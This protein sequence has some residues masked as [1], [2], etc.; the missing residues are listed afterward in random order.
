MTQPLTQTQGQQKTRPTAPSQK[1]MVCREG[2]LFAGRYILGRMLTKTNYST[3]YAAIFFPR[4]LNAVTNPGARLPKKPQEVIIKTTPA[5]GKFQ[6]RLFIE[7]EV[8]RARLHP[9]HPRYLDHG[10][11]LN[12]STGE[13]VAFLGM[14]RLQGKTVFEV[15][16]ERELNLSEAIYTIMVLCD[17]LEPLHQRNLLYR[18][19]S[20]NNIILSLF[21][22]K[23]IDF[24]SIFDLNS[25]RDAATQEKLL[26]GSEDYLAPEHTVIEVKTIQADIYSLGII[27]YELITN[28]NPMSASIPA[29]TFINHLNKAMPALSPETIT[30][31]FH[32]LEALRHR[33]QIDRLTETLDNITQ[34]ATAKKA[35]GRQTNLMMLREE[36]AAARRLLDTISAA[37]INFKRVGQLI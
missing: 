32:P 34:K 25:Q 18:D 23:L 4:L 19:L 12:P 9:A 2:Q 37:E 21:G 30:A 29:Q 3:V 17:A 14:E 11:A 26:I 1:F 35:S 8:L 15:L 31:K 22:P 20:L 36:L 28:T 6:Q 24:G 7:A 33:S 13:Q 27:L 5:N 16:Q 10:L